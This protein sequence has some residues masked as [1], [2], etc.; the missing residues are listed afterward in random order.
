VN[1]EI[2]SFLASVT[3]TQFYKNIESDPIECEFVF[4]LDDDGVITD[5]SIQFD[6]VSQ[7]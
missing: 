3:L 1:A 4:P 6:D 2:K 5:I 7:I